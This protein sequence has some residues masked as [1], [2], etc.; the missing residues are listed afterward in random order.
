MI[1]PEANIPIRSIPFRPISLS[2]QVLVQQP[3]DG[4]S[5]IFQD[6]I[7]VQGTVQNLEGEPLGFAE[8]S[9]KRAGAPAGEQFQCAAGRDGRYELAGLEAAAYRVT[10]L[11]YT[12]EKGRAQEIQLAE[13][14]RAEA[15]HFAPAEPVLGARPGGQP[16]EIRLAPAARRR[17]SGLVSHHGAPVEGA[18]VHFFRFYPEGG[19]H[20]RKNCM[21]TGPGGMFEIA[22]FEPGL[23][24][25]LVTAEAKDFAF[26][27]SEPV[28]LPESGEVEGVEVASVPGAD[29]E[30]RAQDAAGKPLPD[31]LIEL[32][33][34]SELPLKAEGRTDSQGRWHLRQLPPGDY[35][36]R[37]SQSSSTELHKEAICRDLEGKPLVVILPGGPRQ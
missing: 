10:V 36:L 14:V 16:L 5:I 33:G 35:G 32:E 12:E 28:D 3:K 20:Y 15:D 21:V 27:R 1:E 37:A 4:L 17:V 2:A 30:V 8:L 18:T 23:K 26:A 9:W 25:I 22:E 7:L 24:H 11:G 19:Y 6:G 13:T 31:V 29:F 34:S